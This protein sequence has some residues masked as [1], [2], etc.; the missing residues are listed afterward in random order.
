MAVRVQAN[1][2]YNGNGFLDSRQDVAETTEDL[3]NWF[4]EEDSKEI[5]R[6]PRG[7]EVN[8]D[9]IWYIY[10]PEKEENEKTGKFHPRVDKDQIKELLADMISAE[11]TGIVVEIDPNHENFQ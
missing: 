6:I 11:E 2:L 4:N 9:G 10:D 8:V 5:L 1:Y 3:K 7:F